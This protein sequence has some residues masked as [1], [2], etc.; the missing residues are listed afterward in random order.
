M[1]P[2]TD[3]HQFVLARNQANIRTNGVPTYDQDMIDGTRAWSE[4]P[5]N[6]PEWGVVDGNL[7]FYGFNDYQ[8][9][10]MTDFAPTHQHDLTISGGTENS[11]YYVS[12]GHLSKDGY[13]RE[14][15][16]QF[17]RYNILMKGEFKVNDWL[18]LDEKVMLN[19][20]TND[21]PAFYNWDVNINSLA[22]VPPNR[23]IQFPDLPFYLNP[24]DREQYEQYIGMY[25]G[26]TNFFPYLL[27]GG[28]ESFN[29]YD[30]WM[31]TGAT[32]TPLEGLEIKTNFSYNIY[33]DNWQNVES[34]V[35]VISTDLT[36]PNPINN[37]FSG[38]DFIE[39]RIDHNQYYVFNLYGRYDFDKIPG[40]NFSL[41]VGYN[42]E[43]G[44]RKRVRTR[45]RQLI[46][47][48]ITDINATTG[49][50]ETFGRND[51]TALRGAFYRF[52]YNFKD[53]YLFEANGR[54]DGTS[55]FPQDSRFGLFPS[56]SVGWRLSNE[57]FMAWSNDFIENLK[58]RASYG[59][60]GNQLLGNNFYPYV[61]T[62]GTGQSRFLMEG[63][64]IPFVSAA[65]LVSPALTWE[66]VV[67]RNIGLDFT[68]FDGRLDASFDLYTRETR[69]ML[70]RVEYP[71]LLGTGA[72]EENAADLRTSGWELAVTWKNRPN[73]DW[74]YDVTL[75]LSD[76]T[77]EI[78]EFMNP[79]GAL[80]FNGNGTL[81][82]YYE[83][84]R[85]GEIWGYET[86]GI[87]QS[88]DEVTNAPNQDFVGANWRAGDIQYRDLNGD[89][90]INTGSN[91]LEDS[92]DRTIIGNNQPRWTF[93]VNSGVSYKNFRLTAFFQ[94]YMQRDHW[95]S[96]GNW[97]WFFPFNAGHVENYFITDSWSEDNRDAYFAAPHI[98]TNDKK[99]IQVQ[100]RF[101]QNAAYIRLKNLMLSYDLPTTLVSK[102]GFGQ[103]QIYFTGMNLWEY[104]PIRPPL[105]PETIFAGA[106]EYPMQRIYALGARVSF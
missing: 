103:A 3:P 81:R 17:R 34:K 43:W 77:A 19:V 56:F 12:F 92:G 31:T 18:T 4:D 70:M 75:A 35:E 40:H 91:T 98:S 22:R 44:Q 97:T 24:G 93:G 100:D 80:I 60:L 25:F 28:R 10:I 8:E 84:Q 15:N 59:T 62:M 11:N 57:N 94:G 20:Q 45:A 7:R 88:D 72:P 6:A 13:L 61:A 48:L 37:G 105:D 82:N 89:G 46:T 73:K 42:Q 90:E 1:D 36:D 99:N 39:N 79:T 16:E 41:M 96:S 14:N 67:S 65:G 83:G 32:M 106:I 26:G 51:D 54:Y 55:R 50:Q 87:F 78:T 58:I 85:I 64:Q 53:R 2:M 38:D 86:V 63:Q 27:D 9:S 23:P 102:A 74:G 5:A 29:R 21:Q 68:L 71:S 76:W 66:T 30:T 95:P 49:L 101:L 47:P 104:S 52:S 33:Q 69:D